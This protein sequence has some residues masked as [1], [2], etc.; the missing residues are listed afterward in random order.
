MIHLPP[1]ALD[2]L[3]TINTSLGETQR[4]AHDNANDPEVHVG[5]LRIALSEI[6]ASIE[7]ARR[8]ISAICTAAVTAKDHTS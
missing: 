7:D 4:L 2:T 8:Q 1:A 5:G 6:A 3:S